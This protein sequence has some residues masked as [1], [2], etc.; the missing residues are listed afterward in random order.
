M[1]I[2]EIVLIAVLLVANA[3]FVGFEF[4]LQLLHGGGNRLER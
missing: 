4:A 2:G 1:T 3:F